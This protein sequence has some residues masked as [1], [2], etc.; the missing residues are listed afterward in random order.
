M[1]VQERDENGE[2]LNI[3]PMIST[4]LVA[5]YETTSA[6]L[7]YALYNL[8]TRPDIE[9]DLV[10]EIRTVLSD[11]DAVNG[12]RMDFDVEK[13]VLCKALI[14]ETLRLRPIVFQTLR[15]I[16]K[17]SKIEI[18]G[19]EF[20]GPAYIRVPIWAI[21]QDPNN[22][23]RPDEFLPERWA[24][25]CKSKSETKSNDNEW[26]ERFPDDQCEEERVWM[27]QTAV[28]PANREAFFAFS[29]GSR[30]CVGRRFAYQE[31]VIVLA[32]LIKDLKFEAEDGYVCLPIKKGVTQGPK[33]G[34]P[35][36]IS[37]RQ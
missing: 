37:K 15:S 20:T 3:I 10:E 34:M 6:T 9:H 2:T 5:G 31:A 29:S 32:F 13:L 33:D 30:N 36:H 23:P 16:P 22:F 7:T 25:K 28:P 35:M 11:P 27:S 24:R 21:Q 8:S 12:V 18:N 17:G 4:L 14:N 19:L 26:V 1:D